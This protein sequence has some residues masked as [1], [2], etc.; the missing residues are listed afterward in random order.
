MYYNVDTDR[1]QDIR[2]RRLKNTFGCSGIAVYDYLLCEI[3]KVQGCFLECDESCAFDVAEYFNIKE[4][5]VNEII[6]Y[7]GSVG[8]FNKG[9]LSRGMLTSNSIQKRYT[10]MCIRARRT[11]AIIP[12]E[13]RIIPEEMP[14]I[15]EEIDFSTEE[16]PKT[17]EE[18]TEEKIDFK[19]LV[20]FF[21]ETTQGKFGQVCF[22]ISDKRKQ[23]IKARIKEHKKDAFIDVIKKASA[24]DFLSGQSGFVMTFDWMI[25]PTNFEKILSGNY[26]NRKEVQPSK[27]QHIVSIHD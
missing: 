3:Y 23:L 7:C 27:Q 17:T 11:D 18:I 2:I 19:K 15:T 16:M 10:E 24:S 1:Y 26:D 14:I 6:A 5:T 12:E 9:L 25:R 8:L 4:S 20:E 13:I 22:P 21:N